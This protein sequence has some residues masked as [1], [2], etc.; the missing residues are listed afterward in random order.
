[1]SWKNRTGLWLTLAVP[2]LAAALVVVTYNSVHL[3]AAD[4][5]P[6]TQPD[7][8]DLENS[9]QSCHATEFPDVYWYCHNA[10]PAESYDSRMYLR[11]HLDFIT[12][13]L[14]IPPG[15]YMPPMT[16]L[17]ENGFQIHLFDRHLFPLNAN[18][19]VGTKVTWTNLDVRDFTIQ[20]ITPAKPDPNVF[21]LPFPIV[22]LKPGESFSYTFEQAGNFPYACQYADV[23]P[24]A[25]LTYQSAFGK[26]A[27]AAR[28]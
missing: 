14:T 1:M 8:Y 25:T 16:Q 22:T 21:P 18:I 28:Q 5:A 19:S 13:S 27:V 15:L 17:P 2:V 12:P 10:L 20:S 9:C 23:R 7:L 11:I 3:S 4:T 24:A 6:E 26:I